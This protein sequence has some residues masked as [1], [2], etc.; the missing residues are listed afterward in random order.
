MKSR[1][2]RPFATSSLAVL[3][4]CSAAFSA[5]AA[6]SNDQSAGGSA[7]LSDALPVQ[8]IVLFSTG[9]GYFQRGGVVE[10]NETV[11]LYFNT[12]DINDLLK[13]MILQDYDGGQISS[14]NYASRESLNVILG[15]LAINLSGN[16]GIAGILSQLRGEEIILEPRENAGRITGRIIGIENKTAETGV[17]AQFLNIY[18]KWGI[19]DIEMTSIQAIRF[20]DPYLDSEFNK[21]LTLIVESRSSDEKR[22]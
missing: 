11:D 21:A 7:S 22:G 8:G 13:S 19:R 9:L 20:A 12:G 17:S 16:P 18:S 4:L 6:G 1:F 5:Y 14:V 15:S 3:L 2:S 10:G